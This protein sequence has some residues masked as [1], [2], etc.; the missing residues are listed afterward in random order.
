MV[1]F[2]GKNKLSTKLCIVVSFSYKSKFLP[3]NSFIFDLYPSIIDLTCFGTK[4]S[5]SEQYTFSSFFNLSAFSL[6]YKSSGKTI[7]IIFFLSKTK[8]SS[9]G[10]N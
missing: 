6:I 1:N 3:I 2:F 9:L 4:R 7:D 5:K 10:T 8:S